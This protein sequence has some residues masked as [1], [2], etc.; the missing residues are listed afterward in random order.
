[1]VN[2]RDPVLVVVSLLTTG[3]ELKILRR[4]FF[5]TVLKIKILFLKRV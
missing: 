1:M 5:N 2:G 3:C 4:H